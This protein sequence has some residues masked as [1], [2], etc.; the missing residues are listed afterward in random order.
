MPNAG[1]LISLSS[2]LSLLTKRLPA[3]ALLLRSGSIPGRV[4]AIRLTMSTKTGSSTYS[5]G[6]LF[7]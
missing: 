1:R 5:S 2:E 4:L 7:L 6:G 3:L